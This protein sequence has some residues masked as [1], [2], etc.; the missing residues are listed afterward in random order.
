MAFDSDTLNTIYA[1]TQGFCHRCRRKLAF[2]RF[3]LHDGRGAWDI[4]AVSPHP[5]VTALLPG[6]LRCVQKPTPRRLPKSAPVPVAGDD[7]P[8]ARPET[9]GEP[10]AHEDEPIG[11]TALVGG[12]AGAVIGGLW[13]AVL[14]GLIAIGLQLWG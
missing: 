7:K 14:G 11:D 12:A 13:G 6:C 8:A 5:K 1:S 10:S 4:D 2:S 3:G 9:G